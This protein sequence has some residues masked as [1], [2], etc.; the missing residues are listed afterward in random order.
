MELARSKAD[1]QTQQLAAIDH[2]WDWYCSG[3]PPFRLAG[4]AGTGKTTTI[5]SLPSAL[6]MLRF[7]FCAPTNKAANVLRG[8]LP[9]SAQVTTVHGLI[10][11]QRMKEPGVPARDDDGALIFDALD[12]M[13]GD[14]DLVVVD[15]ASM[16]DSRMWSDLTSYGVPVLAVGDP[17]QLPPVR[18]SFC[19]MKSADFTLTD[20]QR[21]VADSPIIRLAYMV[22]SGD[23]VPFGELGQG[24]RKI[25]YQRHNP[26]VDG[27]SSVALA[28]RNK[29]VAKL[30]K[31]AREAQGLASDYVE[32]GEP[33]ISYSSDPLRGIYNNMSGRMT[34]FVPDPISDALAF[35]RI[36]IDGEHLWEGTV[37]RDQFAHGKALRDDWQYRSRFGPVRHACWDYAYAL[38]V[39]RAQGSEWDAVIVDDRT[40]HGKRAN[41]HQKWLY[42]AITRAKERLTI[43]GGWES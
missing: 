25:R 1:L 40:Y 15:E 32:P 29:T 20:I 11:K 2:I 19:L 5:A 14:A 37:H 24:V 6:P 10:Y 34:E 28:W 39:H 17:F 42:T 30:N 36:S 41:D 3:G 31:G 26:Q 9:G 7:A 18:D 13:R 23:E 33:V 8:K 43:I 22:R 16:I 4:L 27:I 12:N 38:T 35:A 21:Q